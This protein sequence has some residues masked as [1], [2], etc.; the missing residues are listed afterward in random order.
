LILHNPIL[1]ILILFQVP[2]QHVDPLLLE[3]ALTAPVVAVASP[4]AV[5]YVYYTEKRD[6]LQMPEAVIVGFEDG[7]FCF[8]D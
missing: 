6:P 5:R 2:V 4:S 1:N 3:Q 8:A 7:Y